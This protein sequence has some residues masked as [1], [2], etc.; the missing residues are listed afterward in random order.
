MTLVVR[1][2]PSGKFAIGSFGFVNRRSVFVPRDD[3][4]YDTRAEAEDVLRAEKEGRK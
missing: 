4:R 3:A 2:L 1:Q